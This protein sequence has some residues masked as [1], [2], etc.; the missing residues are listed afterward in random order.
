VGDSFVGQLGLGGYEGVGVVT[1]LATCV[2]EGGG[3][4][5]ARGCVRRM[6]DLSVVDIAA[7]SFHSLAVTEGGGVYSWGWNNNGQLGHGARM[8]QPNLNY[9]LLIQTLA[10]AGTVVRAVAAGFSHSLALDGGGG[11][12]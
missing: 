5:V 4:D 8:T 12:L 2:E 1:P 7:G 11:A 10:A 6:F 9:P 3:G